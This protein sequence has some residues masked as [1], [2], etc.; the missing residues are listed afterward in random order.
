MRLLTTKIRLAVGLVGIMLVVFMAATAMQLV[1]GTESSRLRARCDYCESIAI[2][3]SLL[4]QNNQ[5]GMLDTVLQQAVLRNKDL[6]SIGVRNSHDRLI[7]ETESHIELWGEEVDPENNTQLSVPLLSGNR[8]WGRIEFTFCSMREG[9]GIF[10]MTRWTRLALFMGASTFILYLIYLGYMLTQLNPSKTVPNRVRNAL[11]NLTEGLLVLDTKGRIVLANEAFCQIVKMHADKLLGKRPETLLPWT[12]SA[13]EEVAEFPWHRAAS[14]GEHVTGEIM[15]LRLTNQQDQ[16]QLI[17]KVNCASVAAESRSGNGVLISFE[18][19][20]ELENSKKAAESANKAKSEFLANMSHEI[21][22]PMNAILGFT[23]WLRR[24]LAENRDEELEYLSTIHSSGRHLMELIND[25]LDLSKIEAGRMEIDKIQRSPHAVIHDVVNFLRVRA[26]DKSIYL[27]VKFD[28]PLPETIETDDV[29]LRQVITNLV[30]NA[31]KF[32]SDGGVTIRTMMIREGGRSMLKV[33]IEDTG[34]GMTP[35]QLE[36]IFKPFVQADASVTRKFGGTGLGLAISKRIVTALGG[37]VSVESEAG[38][39]TT[40]SFTIGVGDISNVPLTDYETFKKNTREQRRSEVASEQFRLPPARILVVD[41]GKANRRLIK[42]VLE[43]AGCKL[44]EA[45]NGQVALDQVE[46]NEYD[47][48]LMD[49]QM[50]VLDGFQATSRLRERGFTNPI[51]ALTANAMTG[52]QEKCLAAGCDKFLPKPIDLDLLVTTLNTSLNVDWSGENANDENPNENEPREI[53][54][55]DRALS[56]HDTGSRK[57]GQ[58]AP[59][60]QLPAETESQSDEFESPVPVDDGCKALFFNFSMQEHLEGLQNAW[61]SGSL[62]EVAIVAEGFAST[63]E[64]Y[65]Q[66]SLVTGLKKLAKYCSEGNPDGASQAL[67]K[68]LLQARE[69]VLNMSQVPADPKPVPDKA[70]GITPVRKTKSVSRNPFLSGGSSLRNP[71]SG[72]KREE[73]ETTKPVYSSL[74]MDQPEFRE[75]VEEFIPVLR[76]KLAEMDRA[77]AANNPQEVAD[78]AHWLKGA[79]GTVGFNEFFKPAAELEQAAKSGQHDAC[80]QWLRELQTIA[81]HI[82]IAELETH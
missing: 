45:E 20:T 59:T 79:G 27:K 2:S 57:T 13:G 75:I 37:T 4:I 22:T 3:S 48:I 61:D 50:P 70:G 8:Q 9:R 33:A 30:G 76:E 67:E 82:V 78:L 21:R 65:E 19:V 42:L 64:S 17:F 47:A 38:K 77:L 18:N 23:D 66:T 7:I 11:N 71:V 56:E 63:A 24:G 58:S 15:N 74:P 1:P 41:D 52:D 16:P 46:K 80:V 44:D 55:R 6:R 43:K 73:P 39:G 81:D 60:L 31:I 72:T 62:D 28:Q 40:F 32:T 36:K 12:D 69:V 51:I 68:F 26:E 53:E 10:G 54:P 25:I 29:R 34:I 5:F 14:S 49:M 35:E